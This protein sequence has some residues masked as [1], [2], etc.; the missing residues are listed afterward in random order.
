MSWRARAFNLFLRLTVRA[1]LERITRVDASTAR[2]S[3]ARLARIERWMPP[4]PADALV[5]WIDDPDIRGEWVAARGARDEAALLYLHGGAYSVGTP[6]LYRELCLKLSAA[7]GL[8]VLSLDYRLAPEHPFPA[9]VEDALGAWQ[10]LRGQ[11]FP[12]SRLAIAGD[13]AGGGLA[14]AT[15]LA[16]RDADESLPACAFGLAPWTDLRA[17]GESV[18]LNARSDPYIVARLL[19]P[20][21]ELYLNGAD[22]GDPLASPLYGDPHG[23]PPLLLHVSEI[24]VLLSDSL[25]FAE[26]AR[27]AGVAMEL[28]VWPEMAHV[29]QLF[30]RVIP[31]ARRSIAEIGDFC[32]R[33]IEA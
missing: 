1:P 6:A 31:E 7:S 28:K 4:V 2:A 24:E 21:A 9:A 27:A 33:H 12:A 22:P 11:G 15:L 19:K 13:S 10:W 26:Q 5:T 14:L 29:F 18:M 3:R 20:V 25:R 17:T 16:L 30:A 8:R 32:R 23:L